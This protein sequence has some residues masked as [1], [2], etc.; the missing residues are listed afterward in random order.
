MNTP[1]ELEA[2]RTFDARIGKDWFSQGFELYPAL[3]GTG[4]LSTYSTDK[5]FLD[6]FV[7][8]AQ[9]GSGGST[10][11]FWTAQEPDLSKAPVVIFG[12]EGGAHIVA[13]NIKDLLA[14][15]ACDT[16]PSCD[17]DKVYYFKNE[18]DEPSTYA[19]EY[20]NWISDKFGIHVPV[21]A[22]EIV[23]KAQ[24]KHQVEFKQWFSIYMKD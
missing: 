14:I 11:A 6:G 18:D 15:L 2:L 23:K 19:R 1:P 8:F 24:E 5:N 17:W 21:T 3:G 13:E 16:E 10:Y 4:M 7:E 12:N 22:D 9:A 20:G